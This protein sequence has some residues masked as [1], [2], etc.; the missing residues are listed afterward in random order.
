MGRSSPPKRRS[1]GPPSKLTR[2]WANTPQG[3]CNLV[4]TWSQQRGAALRG[5][6][7]TPKERREVENNQNR[8]FVSLMKRQHSRAERIHIGW[9]ETREKNCQ[10]AARRSAWTRRRVQGGYHHGRA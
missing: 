6:R 10:I 8:S 3:R 4:V 1:R 9:Y 2:P 7:H 5:R